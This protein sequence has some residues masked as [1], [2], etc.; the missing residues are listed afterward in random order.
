MSEPSVERRFV[1]GAWR[2]VIRDEPSG[3][4]Q[5]SA[6]TDVKWDTPGVG[7][8]PGIKILDVDA[9]HV[10]I[11][12]VVQVTELFAGDGLSDAEI[13]IMYEWATGTSDS[14]GG[15]AFAVS[16]WQ[17]GDEGLFVLPL[18]TYTASPPQAL[19]DLYAWLRADAALSAGAAKVWTVY[20]DLE[21]P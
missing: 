13:G 14:V 11:Y 21:T 8:P 12:A 7:T 1:G 19:T 4:L 18:A 16:V 15:E 5:L 17:A 3:P 2:W 10:P 9:A 20:V 6:P